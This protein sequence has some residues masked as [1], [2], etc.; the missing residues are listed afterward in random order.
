MKVQHSVLGRFIVPDF[1]SKPEGCSLI[2]QSTTEQIRPPQLSE[3]VTLP[4]PIF[5][6]RVSCCCDEV[7]RCR[8]MPNGEI[9]VSESIWAVSRLCHDV[10][11]IQ[12]NPCNVIRNWP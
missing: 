2:N 3:L 11:V 10:L 6:D 4:F 7:V 1:L 12:G 9:A 8:E 5:L